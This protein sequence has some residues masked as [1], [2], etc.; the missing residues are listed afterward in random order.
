MLSRFK[1]VEHFRL[2]V[3]ISKSY[4]CVCVGGGVEADALTVQGS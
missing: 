1:I 3:Y 4:L 2:S